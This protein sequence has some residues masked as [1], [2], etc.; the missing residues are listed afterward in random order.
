MAIDL[1]VETMMIMKIVSD[2][3]HEIVTMF[4]HHGILN[5]LG[6]LIITAARSIVS[7]ILLSLFH[8]TEEET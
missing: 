7:I 6:H 2:S 8:I 1:K 4:W 5:G 3:P